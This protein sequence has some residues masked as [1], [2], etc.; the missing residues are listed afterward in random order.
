MPP[1]I[2][3]GYALGWVIQQ[4]PNGSIVQHITGPTWVAT[5]LG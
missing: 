2:A 3:P 4:T 5:R 1:T